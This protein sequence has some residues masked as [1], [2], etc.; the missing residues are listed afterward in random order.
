MLNVDFCPDCNVPR[1]LSQGHRWMNDGSIV[2]KDNRNVR[3]GMI[4]CEPLDPLFLRIEKKVGAALY[5]LIVYHTACR[6]RIYLESLVPEEVR[7]SIKSGRIDPGF[8]AQPVITLSRLMGHGCFELKEYHVRNTPGDYVTSLLTLPFSVP[9]AVGCY[10]G[11]IAALTGGTSTVSYSEISP[12]VY[13]VTARKTHTV[14]RDPEVKLSV[15]EEP[16]PAEE[17]SL[18]RCE[19][20]NAPKSLDSFLWDPRKGILVDSVNG[21]RVALIGLGFLD[22]LF[23][24]LESMFGTWVSETVIRAQRERYRD[25][26]CLIGKAPDE[27]AIRSEIALCG[28]GSLRHFRQA[29]GGLDLVVDNA[30]G[31]LLT[32]GIAQGMFEKSYGPGSIAEWQIGPRRTLSVRINP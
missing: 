15:E 5:P 3:M 31:W 24:K 17:V 10:A 16:S 30:T 2:Q 25:D 11:G 32:V 22:Q 6:S 7:E 29:R 23:C 13:E 9:E 21:R 12:G 8:L 4:E 27:D 28:L 26:S 18:E 1:A 20:C 14:K 19:Q